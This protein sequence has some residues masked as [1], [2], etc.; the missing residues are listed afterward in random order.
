MKVQ[1]ASQIILDWVLKKY[2]QFDLV[3]AADKTIRRPYGWIFF[4]TSKKEELFGNGPLVVLRDGR[5]TQLGTRHSI[6]DRITEFEDELK[7]ESLFYRILM[8]VHPGREFGEI[9]YPT[10]V[11]EIDIPEWLE[12]TDAQ[13][14]QRYQS[15]ILEPY[16]L[17]VAQLKQSYVASIDRL[18]SAGIK[19]VKLED[20]AAL[21]AERQRAAESDSIPMDDPDI[22]IES[23]RTLRTEYRAQAAALE[24]A[25]AQG[26]RVQ[27]ERYDRQ[28]A[29][30]E[31]LF[32]KR[33][34]PEDAMLVTIRRRKIATEWM[35]K[36]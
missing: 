26:A 25:R 17:G 31:A 9:T 18:L 35:P 7:K 8:F 10:S 6:K 20:V 19:D 34:R 15:Q 4:I 22:P 28:L 27:Y 23:V 2:P 14:R 21:R 16:G 32:T 3:I 13:Y 11:H 5:V 36:L 24:Q 29:S 1:R 30:N 33:Q 12:G